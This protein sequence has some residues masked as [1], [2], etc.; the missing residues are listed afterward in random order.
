MDPRAQVLRAKCLQKAPNG[1]DLIIAAGKVL[2]RL[3]MGKIET[4]AA[5]EQKLPTWLAHA[6]TNHHFASSFRSQLCGH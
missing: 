5:G 6:V 4:I 2:K 3:V 1:F